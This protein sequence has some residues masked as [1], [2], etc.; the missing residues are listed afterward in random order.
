MSVATVNGY[1]KLLLCAL[2]LRLFGLFLMMVLSVNVIVQ[3]MCIQ[4]TTD[5]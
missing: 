2:L 1:V 3:F 4:Y 5:W